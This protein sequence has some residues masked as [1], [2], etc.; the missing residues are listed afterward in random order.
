MTTHAASTTIRALHGLALLSATLVFGLTLGHVL[1][2][3]GSLGLDGTAWLA[4]MHTSYG[5]FAVVGG[6]AEV[7][8]LVTAAW[9]AVAASR[10]R[11]AGA[12]TGFAV[13]AVAMAG[14]LV[15]Y[16]LGNRPVNSLVAAWTPDTLPSDWE[17]YRSTWET[18]H[19]VSA[20][21]SAIAFVALALVLLARA[22]PA[23]RGRNWQPR[24][25]LV[26]DEGGSTPL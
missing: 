17:A 11:Q 12:A 7:L 10:R 22:Y 2:A 19:A 4:V 13:A 24:G 25:R 16:W 18:A 14:T 5:G 8:G 23:R 3:P 1:Q 9:A 26:P 6:I 15:S 20:G 21:L